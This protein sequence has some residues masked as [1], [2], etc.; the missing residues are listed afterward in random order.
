M[1]VW[2]VITYVCPCIGLCTHSDANVE[3]P[4]SLTLCIIQGLSLSLGLGWQSA[5]TRNLP[6]SVPDST[7]VKVHVA[8]AGISCGHWGIGTQDLL[9]VQQVLLS[10]LSHLSSLGK[11]EVFPREVL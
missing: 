3:C 5:S 8:T 6:V 10:P 1:C 7:W 4:C 2:H 9:L 11:N